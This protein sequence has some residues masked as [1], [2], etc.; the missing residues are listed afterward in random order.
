[1]SKDSFEDT[2][3]EINKQCNPA[4]FDTNKQKELNVKRGVMKRKLTMFGKLLDSITQ[5]PVLTALQA[6]EVECRLSK[7]DSLYSDFDDLQTEAELLCG[8]TEALERERDEFEKIYFEQIARART[9]LADVRPSHSST[10]GEEPKSELAPTRQDFVRLPKIDLPHFSGDY[11]KWLE[12]RDTYL[13]L[14]HNNQ[15]I[16]EINKF[17]YLRA[18]LRGDALNIIQSLD[19]TSTNYSIA[20][21]LLTER[22]DN[23]KILI[24]NHLQA[25]LNLDKIQKESSDSLRT[26]IDTINKN[27]RSLAALGQPT[28]YWD[29]LIIHVMAQKLDYS[30]NLKWEEFRNNHA[31]ILDLKQFLKFLSNRADL[32]LTIQNNKQVNKTNNSQ[33]QSYN[34]NTT[35]KNKTFTVS[36]ANKPATVS[37]PLCDQ[38]HHLYNCQG[39]RDLDVDA[40]ILKVKHFSV[41][42]NCL[43]PGHTENRC[44]LS[45]CKYCTERHNTL[46]HKEKLE[47]DNTQHIALSTNIIQTS[48]QTHVLLSTALVQ[49]SDVN[50]KLHTARLLLDNGSTSNFVTRDFFEELGLPRESTDSTIQG[51]NNQ[52]TLSA[53]SCNL[54]IKSRV[55]DYTASL[56]C[57]IL[58]SITQSLPST[59]ID[60][61]TRACVGLSYLVSSW[62]NNKDGICEESVFS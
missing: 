26:M 47:N 35:Q 57:Y 36:T 17:H 4:T 38:E 32:L 8:S 2:V 15:T 29:T 55:T 46:L 27:L 22:F 5:S 41:C 48:K 50:G 60:T 20:W 49:V 3:S 42:T 37:C 1:M 7:I 11:Q 18:A 25:L 23:E 51:I 19:F 53:E 56:D 6:A 14:I 13:S 31:D 45:H 40:R 52:L 10:C 43:R 54:T 62:G 33:S 28:H 61:H 34:T 39:F 12:F 58:P 21:N 9:M 24:S 16:N 59:Y 44:R 30:S